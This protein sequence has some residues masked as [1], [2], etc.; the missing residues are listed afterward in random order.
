MKRTIRIYRVALNRVK[1]GASGHE[2]EI[3]KHCAVFTVGKMMTN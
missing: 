2:L 3:V 1:L